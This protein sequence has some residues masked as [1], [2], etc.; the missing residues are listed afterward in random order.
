MKKEGFS[1]IEVIVTV[2]LFGLSI[3]FGISV[4][5]KYQEERKKIDTLAVASSYSRQFFDLRAKVV[6]AATRIDFTSFDPADGN[7]HTMNGQESYQNIT[8]QANSSQCGPITETVTV[9]CV[10]KHSQVPSIDLNQISGPRQVFVSCAPK[11]CGSS[12]DNILGKDGQ[13]PRI[14]VTRTVKKHD[15]SGNCLNDTQ[16]TV[17]FF[18][19][20]EDL[21]SSSGREGNPVAAVVCINTPVGAKLAVDGIHCGT[22]S[23]AGKTPP[24]CID[25][26]VSKSSYSTAAQQ[27]LWDNNCPLYRDF[28]LSIFFIAQV[29]KDKFD[30][31]QQVASFPRP[32]LL[33]PKAAKI[34]GPTGQ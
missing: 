12:T 13:L 22:P 3:M 33:D 21:L 16:D 1:L 9:D 24:D 27:T 20:S 5:S 34:L 4:Y 7:I 31:A 23:A 14:K 18:P 8:I 28:G 19:Q 32:G 30:L 25:C 29:G 2:G 11:A 10:P 6:Q 26:E 17:T 15:T